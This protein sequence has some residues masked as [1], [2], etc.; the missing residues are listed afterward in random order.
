MVWRWDQQEPFGDSPANDDPDGNSIA[1][2][3]PLRLPGQY[4]DA[5]SGLHYNYFREY[6]PGLGIYKESDPIDLRGGLNTYAYSGDD[7]LSRFDPRGEADVRIE[8]AMRAA[9]MPIPTPPP[10]VLDQECFA[11]CVVVG[12]AAASAGTSVIVKKAAKA[13]AG[14]AV[15]VVAEGAKIVVDHPAVMV[16]AAAYGADYCWRHCRKTPSCSPPPEP[17]V[18]PFVP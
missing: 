8:N 16:V 18:G 3:L 4:Y 11:R 7:P 5:E 6:D 2:N 10:G 15:G 9:G 12:K 13:T 1:F 14:T 17:M